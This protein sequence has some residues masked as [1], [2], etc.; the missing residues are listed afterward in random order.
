M[1]NA[2]GPASCVSFSRTGDFFAS[3]GSDE[4]VMVWRTNFDSMDYSEVLEQK[5]ARNEKT[6]SVHSRPSA[7]ET[8]ATGFTDGRTSQRSGSTARVRPTSVDS[9]S[10]AQ[11]DSLPA[12]LTST[13]QHI[14]GQ[15][16]VLTQT[17]AILEQR[18]TLTE[19][20]LKECME[21]QRQSIEKRAVERYSASCCTCVARGAGEELVSLIFLP[22]FGS[23]WRS[24]LDVF[25]PDLLC[26]AAAVGGAQ[27]VR[28][29]RHAAASTAQLS[30][31]FRSFQSA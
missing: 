6:S 28:V 2:Q 29:Q 23:L 18:L 11:L 8:E 5:G 20:K 9:P 17:V 31:C 7:Q 19:D 26:V 3:G 22:L 25:S 16:D 24:H 12:A 4:Q 13:L 1:L 27:C 30:V 10:D 14:V 21:M 15:L